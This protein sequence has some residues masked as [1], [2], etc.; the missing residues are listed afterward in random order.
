MNTINLFEH[1]NPAAYSGNAEELEAF[2][3]NIWMSRPKSSP[4][5]AGAA[6]EDNL[7]APSPSKQQFI[8]FPKNGAIKSGK[9]IGIINFNGTV[10]NL[11]PKIFYE[12][13][14][15]Y[16]SDTEIRGI[17]ANILWWLSYCTKFKFPS[18][19]TGL[20]SLK[21]NFFEIMVY[22]FATYTRNTLNNM[23]HMSYE[24]M[25]NE[26][27]FMKGRLDI[28]SYVKQNLARGNWHKLYCVYESFEFDNL[29]NRIIK[30]VSRL[31]MGASADAENKR[32]LS[33]IIFLLDE[34]SDER[35]T[36]SDC[37]K[38]KLNPLYKDL[39]TVL[40]YCKLFLSNS[41]TYSYKNELKVFAFL[42]PMEYVFEDF[43]F[44][45]IER[46]L[47]QYGIRNLSC[48]KSDLYLAALFENETLVNN[49]VFQIKHDLYFEH[50]DRKIVIDTKYKVLS[51]SG[52]NKHGVAQ[53]DLYQAVSYAIR[54]K[55]NDL[56]LIYP[57]TVI[58]QFKSQ[59][60][61]PSVKFRVT[62]EFSNEKIDVNIIKVPVIHDNFSNIDFS[63]KLETNFEASEAI[64][65]DYLALNLKL[66]QES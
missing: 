50:E 61:M 24:E 38:V 62:D 23:L 36:Y 54:R 12:R 34:V 15:E 51:T 4:G 19:K 28:N 59:E 21:S 26:L 48:Q 25:N 58:S 29:F 57:E 41:T 46:H 6:D 56:C 9:Y 45:F 32:M 16:Y 20:T 1:S 49:N 44:G 66:M 22:F 7:S 14:K 55:S 18:T 60:K 47:Q 52:D 31:L 2:L 35:I 43:I 5:Y 8:T 10:I 33:E 30:F 42:L 65:R 39:I 63:K 53:S 40:D 3:D 64:L 13:N 37:E 11:L 27:P 17:Q